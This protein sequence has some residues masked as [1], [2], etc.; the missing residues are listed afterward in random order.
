MNKPL[1]ALIHGWGMPSLLFAPLVALCKEHYEVLCVTLP[2][3]AGHP[4]QG[5]TSL[6]DFADAVAAQ[7]PRPAIIGGWSLGGLIALELVR[8]YPDKVQQLILLAATPKFIQSE[9]WRSAVTRT[10]F[11]SFAANFISDY[12]KG[13]RRFI[14]MQ[15][16]YMPDSGKL[17]RQLRQL[18]MPEQ[19]P[20]ALTSMLSL[21][22]D[23]D[24]REYLP[25]INVPSVWI[26]GDCDRLSP[27]AASDYAA[28]CIPNAI[29]HTLSPTGHMPFWTHPA[30][31]AEFLL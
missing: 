23:T 13:L 26:A 14:G 12:H 30:R 17:A 8:R 3:D 22:R 25:S 2:G 20:T 31:I 5:E 1:L 4:Y 15:A 7:L 21:L 6:N 11:D 18:S 9:D 16:R 10:D 28:S 24:W 27:P 29:S 19:D